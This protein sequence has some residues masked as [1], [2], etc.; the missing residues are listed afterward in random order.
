L[1]NISSGHQQNTRAVVDCGAVPIFVKLLSHSNV[2]LQEQAIW[3]LGNISGDC[4]PLRDYVISEGAFLP[5]LNIL[6][7]GFPK[8]GLM[9]NATWTI[10]NLCRGKPAPDFTKLSPSLPTL[11]KLLHSNDDEVICDALWALSY[12]SDGSKDRLQSFIIHGIPQKLV[13]FLGHSSDSVKTPAL[14][15]VGNIFTGDDLQT[16]VLIDAGALPYLSKLMTSNHRSS[17]RKEA[18]WAV[19]NIAA[20]NSQQIDA[21]LTSGAI[22]G[23]VA[24]LSDPDRFVSKEALWAVAN[25]LSGGNDNQIQQI[26]ALGCIGKVCPYL[27][28]KDPKLLTL[29]LD[30]LIHIT[31]Y[32]KKKAASE[33]SVEIGKLTADF[34]LIQ[35]LSSG[36]VEEVQERADDLL[37]LLGILE[38]GPIG[39]LE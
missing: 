32:A 5:I 2:D 3:A 18:C 30:C 27:T 9:R 11:L 15:T 6:E 25:A 28:E 23:L 14:R 26:V 12:L 38:C 37:D 34:Q 39:E 7:K 21:V 29:S 36:S 22:N 16:Q 35:S 10:S 8:L 20:G 33:I 4:P 17:L 24:C 13:E 1:T 31:K 19:S